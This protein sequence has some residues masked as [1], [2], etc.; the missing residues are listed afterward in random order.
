ML[1]IIYLGEGCVGFWG[2]GGGYGSLFISL[3]ICMV[4]I[5]IMVV[6]A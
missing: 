2:R 3:S 6:V 1:G 5:F 4:G